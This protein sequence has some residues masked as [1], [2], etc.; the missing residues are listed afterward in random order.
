M[1]FAGRL[2]QAKLNQFLDAQEMGLID[3][4]RIFDEKHHMEVSLLPGI[5][6][7]F[8]QMVSFFPEGWR[9]LHRSVE[10]IREMFE[11]GEVVD[12]KS[13][14]DAKTQTAE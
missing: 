13:A 8:F 12:W 5:S 11:G 9:Y 7:G 6:H 4:R 2:R 14:L 1:T 10:W 3:T